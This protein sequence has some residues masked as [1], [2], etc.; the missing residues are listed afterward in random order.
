LL[1]NDKPIEDL[2]AT[3]IP[4]QIRTLFA[5]ILSTCFPSQPVQLWNKYKNYMAE[6]IL[7][8]MRQERHNHGLDFPEEI[9]NEAL[10][11]IEDLCLAM[12][13][14]LLVQ[15]GVTAPNRSINAT[16]KREL[17]REQSYNRNDLQLF[18]QENTP[19]FFQ[20]QKIAFN[21]IIQA[22]A[23]Q[24]GGLYFLNTPGGTG[25]TFLISLILDKIRSNGHIELA[26]ISSGIVATLM[27]GGIIAHLAL[28]LSLNM[29]EGNHVSENELSLTN[30]T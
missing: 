5:V 17:L 14:K 8:R 27:E 4:F 16:F 13:G 21:T 1:K 7:Y 10:I 15:L 25:N 26:L 20:E 18:V 2:S 30:G 12:C 24:S 3:S 19:K 29:H 28:K 9:Y 22:V 6:N 11:L 23:D